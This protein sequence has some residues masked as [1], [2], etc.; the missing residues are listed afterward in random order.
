MF[1]RAAYQSCRPLSQDTYNKQHT[2]LVCPAYTRK[3][4]KAGDSLSDLAWPLQDPVNALADSVSIE[5]LAGDVLHR[6]PHS[7]LSFNEPLLYIAACSL[8]VEGGLQAQFLAFLTQHCGYLH[9]I[10]AESG[11]VLQLT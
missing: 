5:R 1:K 10:K 3:Q 7:S 8:R 6:L 4:D 11:R 2:D 9:R